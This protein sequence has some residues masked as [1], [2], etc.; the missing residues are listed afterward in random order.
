LQAIFQPVAT[1][2]PLVEERLK[3]VAEVD[4]PQLAQLLGHVLH[5]EGKR[6][7]PALTLLAGRFHHYDLELLIPMATAIELF[8]TATLV[9]DDTIDSSATRRGLP[10]LSTIWGNE[11]AV[12][13][14]D[15]L[16][17][18]SA[19]LV[20]T[21]GN[22][23][24]ITLFAQTLMTICR[25]EL[26]ENFS[27]CDPQQSCHQYYQRSGK[28]TASLFSAAA[29]SGAI[30]SQ[31]PEEAVQALKSYGYNL[32]LAFQIV[33]DIFDFTADEGELGKPVGG[34]LLQGVLTLPAILF[35]EH[36]PDDN[37]IKEILAGRDKEA[38]LKRAIESIRNSPIIAESYGIAQDFSAK[39][40]HALQVLPDNPSRRALLELADYVIQRQR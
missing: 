39:A 3:A 28:K 10:T 23:R 2:I 36:L 8:H 21:T 31:A 1:E 25:G 37:P 35:L 38:N 16:F 34:D 24:V 6:I 18:K 4:F 40:S 30:L 9:H 20:A 27:A 33:D 29:E 14:G 22:I 19:D 26:E 13:A 7:R 5:G 17:A 12:L 11:V 32:G 15:Y